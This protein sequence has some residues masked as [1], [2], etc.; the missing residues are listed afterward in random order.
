MRSDT[1]LC[2]C[3]REVQKNRV[4]KL[5]QDGN[6]LTWFPEKYTKLNEDKYQLIIFVTREEKVSMDVGEVKIEE[7]Y[8]EKLLGITR[9]KKL[10]LKSTP[11]QSVKK[12]VK[13]F[14][15]LR[16]F[17]STWSPSS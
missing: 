5:E 9:D 12:L 3:D 13:S 6:Q 8:D 1:T 2:S 17:Q 16:V 7:S 10:T 11:K 15:H 14:V 4:T